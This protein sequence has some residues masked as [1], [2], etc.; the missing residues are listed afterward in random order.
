MS[1]REDYL[2]SLLRTVTGSEEIGVSAE[3]ESRK[4]EETQSRNVE[5]TREEA[6]QSSLE[7]DFLKEFE[8]E[9]ED[10]NEDDFLKEFEQDLEDDFLLQEP[11]KKQPQPEEPEPEA[12]EEEEFGDLMINTMSQEDFDLPG[13][14]LA[15]GIDFGDSADALGSMNTGPD[16]VPE[17]ASAGEDAELLDIL[18]ALGGDD[19]LSDIGNMLKAHDEGA[20]LLEDDG[21]DEIAE[22]LGDGIEELGPGSGLN[23]DLDLGMEEKGASRKKKKASKKEEKQKE[24]A[25][26]ENAGFLGKLASTLFDEDNEDVVVPEEGELGSISEE[27]M[28]VLKELDKNKKK[29]QKEQKKKEKQAKKAEKQKKQPKK[30][31]PPK[32]P[33]EK[34]PKEKSKPLPKAP[35]ILIYVM[36]ASILVVIF[37]GSRLS[38]YSSG[39]S[40]AKASFDNG[41]YVTAYQQLAGMELKEKDQEFYDRTRMTAYLQKE[42]D[43][44]EAYMGRSMYPEA[45]DAL[46]CAV[47]KYD[48]Y[49]GEASQV[50]ADG[51]L[52]E[53]RTKVEEALA[54]VFGLSMEEARAVYGQPDRVSYTTQLYELL[55]RAG[56][57]A[58]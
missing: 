26:K 1:N 31:K 3:A 2:D 52:E 25:K 20:L 29:E 9:F 53:I 43:S 33:K 40:Q 4:R 48:K 19:D 15:G 32:P 17:A 30:V 10:F 6:Q 35:V 38:G 12:P 36:A 13:D 45:L 50:G 14:D 7:D 21:F 41:D 11:V 28:K 16:K 24:E 46:I 5:K 42:W 47:G 51:E 57:S 8:Q 56:L 27:N 58:E 55:L 34:K 18:S 39:M 37:L 49:I 54:A 23:S 44:Y 22:E